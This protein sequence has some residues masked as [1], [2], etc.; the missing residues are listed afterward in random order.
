[1][2]R[3]DYAQKRRRG[4]SASRSTPKRQPPK[5]PVRR[6]PWWPKALLTL[7]A[8]V[9]L[10]YLLKILITTGPQTQTG[11]ETQPA[12]TPAQSPA[13]ARPAESIQV[14]PALPAEPAVVTPE[15]PPPP[16]APE[17]RFDFYDI[18]PRSE[19]QGPQNVYH[20]TPRDAPDQSRY[21]LQTGSFRAETDAERMRAELLLSGLPN[22][23]T[24]RVEGDNGIWY[25]VRTGPFN[26]R[27][28]LNRARNQLAN[29]GISPLPIP[30]D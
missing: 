11:T 20:S 17:A 9:G 8:L 19:V 25:R 16:D 24:S 21:L 7:A 1:M 12:R 4:T 5:P 28:E 30:L 10:I 3:Q 14:E 2:A 13:P 26:T 23:H 6:K 27:T 22:V 29:L 18:L 15:I